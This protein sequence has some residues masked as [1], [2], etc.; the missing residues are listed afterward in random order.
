MTDNQDSSIGRIVTVIGSTFDAE[1]PEGRAPA[2]TNALRI[3]VDDTPVPVHLTG[4]VQQQLPG[5][6]VRCVALGSTDGLVRGMPVV[7]TRSPVTVPVGP[8]VLGRVFN[9][10]GEPID[11]RGPVQAAEYRSIHASP[12][13]FD[14]L[15]PQSE[16]FETGI[17]VID[18]L[19]PFVRGG[20]TGL[21]GGAGLGKTLISSPSC[22]RPRSQHQGEYCR[23]RQR[24]VGPLAKA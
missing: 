23:H 20:K 18:L 8:G 21:F 13:A 17:K 4:E 19:T 15:T 5:G 7:D 12:P 2:I 16:I 11:G 9:L 6:R 22:L 24:L 10:L 1:F 14:A 3:D